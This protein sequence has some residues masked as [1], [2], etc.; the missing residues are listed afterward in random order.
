MKV[1]TAAM[2]HETNCFSPIP[3]DFNSF[4]ESPYYLPN[5]DISETDIL[6]DPIYGG[7]LSALIDKGHQLEI[8]PAFGAQPSGLT[9]KNDYEKIRNII[10]QHLIQVQDNIDCVA[11]FLHG[12]QMAYEYDDCEGDLLTHIREIVGPHMPVAVLLDLHGNISDTMVEQ[13]SFLIACKEYP[14]TDFPERSIEL[15]SLLERCTNKEVFPV[16]KVVKVPMTGG[17]HTNKPPLRALVDKTMAIEATGQALTISLMH[18]FTWSDSPIT[19]ANALVCT[20]NDMVKATILAK[21]LAEEF[22]QAGKIVADVEKTTVNKA[23]SLAKEVSKGL[24]VIADIADNA[25]GGAP[26]DSTFILQALLEQ[27][28]ENI[29]LGMIWDPQAVKIAM[30]AQVGDVINLRIGGK[31][32]PQSGIPIDVSAEIIGFDWADDPKL[33]VKDHKVGIRV[34]G[35]DIV[36]NSIREQVITDEEF[37]LVGI[38]VLSKSIVVVKSTQHFYGFYGQIAKKVIYCETPGVLSTELFNLDFKHLPRP[39]WPLDDL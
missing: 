10:I 37:A 17:F 22:F 16:T 14:H 15:V 32:C 35:V 38:E 21:S 9:S 24:V 12:A 3:T 6:K 11:L 4:K 34:E 13:A 33:L 39:I 7:L 25:G 18:G 30:K 28:F 8:G 23:L 2:M 5:G 36:L 26:S 31:T 20:D 27:K 19:T 1:F 29:A